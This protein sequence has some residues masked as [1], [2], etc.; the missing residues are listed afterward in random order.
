MDY[1]AELYKLYFRDLV[2]DI[3]R[4]SSDN[5]KSTPESEIEYIQQRLKD[6]GLD[7]LFERILNKNTF[8]QYNNDQV[9]GGKEQEANLKYNNGVD[10]SAMREKYRDSKD[11]I[12]VLQKTCAKYPKKKEQE[13]Y[14]RNSYKQFKQLMNQIGFS[15][16]EKQLYCPEIDILPNG[17]TDI[18]YFRFN[19]LDDNG[20]IIYSQQHQDVFSHNHI[21]ESKEKYLFT[22]ALG[23]MNLQEMHKNLQDLLKV[24]YKENNSIQAM[25]PEDVMRVA[26]YLSDLIPVIDENSILKSEEQLQEERIAVRYAVFKKLLM[27]G[28]YRKK[29]GCSQLRNI[30]VKHYEDHILGKTLLEIVCSKEKSNIDQ[31]LV[32]VEGYFD[33]LGQNL[34]LFKHK[35]EKYREVCNKFQ[36]KPYPI[37]VYRDMWEEV[38]NDSTE[39]E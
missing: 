3:A 28:K 4:Q 37:Q 30:L 39:N 1:A 16:K 23:K 29:S 11:I 35:V 32:I 31:T 34:E 33:L 22:E 21:M 18:K 24:C 38:W 27:E 5:S 36:D 2:K 6:V 25:N 13:E 12:W 26:E 14:D 8:Y 20:E 15:E 19:A 10:F 17:E 7:F 9:V